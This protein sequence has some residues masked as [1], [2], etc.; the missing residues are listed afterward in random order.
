[1]GREGPTVQ[2]GASIMYAMGRRALRPFTR[3][4]ARASA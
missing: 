1:M 3:S 4:A 2:V